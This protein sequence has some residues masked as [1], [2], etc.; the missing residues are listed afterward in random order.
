MTE[1]G[2]GLRLASACCVVYIIKT[3]GVTFAKDTAATLLKS[4]L[5]KPDS[6]NQRCADYE[7]LL[8]VYLVSEQ[9]HRSVFTSLFCLC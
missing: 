6:A 4:L 9:W 2:S 5:L 3:Y 8:D 7:Q 1:A